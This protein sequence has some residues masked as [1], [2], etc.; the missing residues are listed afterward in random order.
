MDILNTI[1]IPVLIIAAIAA[2]LGVILGISS[3][4]LKV[5]S[6]I[7]SEGVLAL[8]PGINCGACGQPGCAGLADAIISGEAKL[9]ECPPLKPDAAA[10]I[11]E[12][13]GKTQ[14]PNGEI[15]DVSKL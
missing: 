7:R 9:K 14:G 3:K 1:I 11:K 13:L 10:A 8:M 5:T 4:F 12:F 2:I 6:D 15:I